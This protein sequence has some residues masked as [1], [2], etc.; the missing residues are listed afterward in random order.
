MAEYC[1]E[2]RF[3]LTEQEK[4]NLA[5]LA[6]QKGLSQSKLVRGLIASEIERHLGQMAD[7]R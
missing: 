6:K 5:S 1:K 3:R 2:I 4:R 7:D